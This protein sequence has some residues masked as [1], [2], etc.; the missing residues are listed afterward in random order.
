MARETAEC[1]K[2]S[3][4]FA[5]HNHFTNHP[6]LP[7]LLRKWPRLQCRRCLHNRLPIIRF[8]TLCLVKLLVIFYEHKKCA[9]LKVYGFKS[10]V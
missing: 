2:Y 7:A 8:A 4:L 1:K 10:H 3:I 5:D 6:C 9:H